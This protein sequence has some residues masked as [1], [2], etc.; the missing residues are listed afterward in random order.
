M[1]LFNSYKEI[2]YFSLI[3]LLILFINIYK[4]YQ[5]YYELISDPQ[6]YII[7][8][9]T[10]KSTLKNG[11]NIITL[12]S[13]DFKIS[14]RVS[15]REKYFNSDLVGLEFYSI[16]VSFIDFLKSSFFVQ[17]RNRTIL[18]STKQ[19]SDE[20]FLYPK[21]P[22]LNG[23]RVKLHDMI[24]SQHES[25]KISELFLAL[26]LAMPI[27]KELRSDVATF[28]ISHLIAISG[29]HLGLIF[30]LVFILLSGPYKFFVAKYCPFR[31]YR[32]DLSIFT[33][34]LLAFYLILIDFMP[35]F[36]RAFVMSI[37]GFFM[38]SRGLKLLSFELFYVC[39]CLIVAF[40]PEFIFN[41]GFIFSCFGIWFIYVFLH[42]FKFKN[43]LMLAFALNAYIFFSMMI[44][45]CFVFGY[46]SLQQIFGLGLNFIFVIFYPLMV[47]LHV[48]GYGGIFDDYILTFLSL[49]LG[50][51]G[52]LD[53]PFL[54][55]LVFAIVAIFAARYKI[56]AYILPISG[57]L[58]WI[59]ALLF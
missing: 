28:G 17:S 50:H 32:L 59:Y 34:I 26:F 31:N 16:N 40:C 3:I 41:I 39:V 27:S 23:L 14:T 4:K 36:F 42:H 1:N 25:Q 56:L 8:I 29:Y 15:K 10:H 11:A 22:L 35:S 19:V 24:S 54:F 45:V 43:K 30:G 18:K 21:T 52:A 38:I 47:F 51:E 49:R 53:I 12:S 13:G 48:L 5:Q 33:F 57:F 46:V 9:V 58:C 44:F 7:G 20:P 2:A 6:P 55:V 37:F